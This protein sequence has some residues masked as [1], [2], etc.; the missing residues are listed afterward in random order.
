MEIIEDAAGITLR[1]SIPKIIPVAAPGANTEWTV[2]VPGGACWIVQSIVA[3]LTT[4]ATV[5][6]RTAM[7][8]VSDGTTVFVRV[9]P[10][11]VIPASTVA[12]ITYV[13]NYGATISASLTAGQASPF[14]SIPIFG[15]FQIA[16]A[17]ENRAA[18]DAYTGIVLYVVE[19]EERPY[20]TELNMD[21]AQMRGKYSAAYPYIPIGV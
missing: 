21:I 3:T 11:A 13:R 1:E 15:G 2:P 19:I 6:N 5:A 12:R 18:G 7:V 10:S 8:T 20:D 14:P 17:T 4:D 9:P 16:S